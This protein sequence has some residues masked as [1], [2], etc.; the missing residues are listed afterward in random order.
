M[1]TFGVVRLTCQ[2]GN[3]IKVRWQVLQH[4]LIISDWSLSKWLKL[5]NEKHEYRKNKTGLGSFLVHGVLNTIY[6]LI[7]W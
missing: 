3:A 7:F 2:Y 6:V 4:A 1:S 5:V